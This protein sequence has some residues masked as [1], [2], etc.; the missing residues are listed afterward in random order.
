[1]RFSRPLFLAGF[2][3]LAGVAGLARP[4][5]RAGLPFPLQ[6]EMRVPFE[7]TAFPSVGQTY[8]AYELYVTN[9][10][11][12]PI[13]L[14]RIEV[15][16]AERESPTPIA[17]F[18]DGQLD[19][20]L[21]VVGGSGPAGGSSP[22]QLAPGSTT[23]AF[24]WLALAGQSHVPSRLRHRVVTTDSEAQVAAIGTHHDEL[25]VLGH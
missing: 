1:M 15:P 19:A 13:G 6:L 23:V 21:Q 16:D 25:H 12:N 14:R 8:L 4:A 20:V 10:A 3:A 7:P 9:F 22:V 17:A 11:G 18:E 2:I 24:M 5:S